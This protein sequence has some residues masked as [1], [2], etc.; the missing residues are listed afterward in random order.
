MGGVS[1]NK[2]RILHLHTLPIVSGSGINTFLSM[3]GMDKTKY[4][5]ELGCAPG[6]RLIE[7][8]ESNGMKVRKA[9]IISIG[10]ELLPFW[11]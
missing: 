11:S 6:G 5:V 2:V 1:K 4:D 7:L 9:A 10:D 3:K 8:V